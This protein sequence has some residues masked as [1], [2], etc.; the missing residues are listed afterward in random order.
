M[1]SWFAGN[2]LT[3]FRGQPETQPETNKVKAHLVTQPNKFGFRVEDDV[4]FGGPVTANLHAS[5]T[6]RGYPDVYVNGEDVTVTVDPLKNAQWVLPHNADRHSFTVHRGAL[7]DHAAVV[8]TQYLQ[9][10][11]QQYQ[12]SSADNYTP[13]IAY[14]DR[15][16]KFTPRCTHNSSRGKAAHG[17]RWGKLPTISK[18]RYD[19]TLPNTPDF[20]VEAQVNLE[21]THLSRTRF[22]DCSGGD[23]PVVPPRV[24]GQMAMF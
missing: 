8:E 21:N 11:Q 6:P 17:A 12:P 2:A 7:K 22:F 18:M 13:D 20:V 24:P 1:A 23:C 14:F 3:L 16:D 10:Q 15:A 19:G 4:Y 5:D 9:Q